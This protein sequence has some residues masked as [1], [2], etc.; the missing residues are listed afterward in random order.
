MTK[1]IYIYPNNIRMVANISIIF[2]IV[3]LINYTVT[4]IITDISI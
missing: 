1:C 4:L 2:I 3:M